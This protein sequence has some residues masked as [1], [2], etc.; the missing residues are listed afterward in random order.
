MPDIVISEFMNDSAVA[1]L[2]ASYDVYYDPSLV[3]RAD[4]LRAKVA[5]ARALIVRDRTQVD[6]KSV[7]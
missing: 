1:E 7:V 5:G 2:T 6:R 3:E 4:A